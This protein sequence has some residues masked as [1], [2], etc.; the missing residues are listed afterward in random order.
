MFGRNINKH[1]YVYKE[2][3]K[4]RLK[5]IAKSKKEMK[6]IKKKKYAHIK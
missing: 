6:R 1:I 2:K 5:Q 4:K 3:K